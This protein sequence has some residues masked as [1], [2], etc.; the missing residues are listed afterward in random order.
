[1]SKYKVSSSRP[2][3]YAIPRKNARR[4]ADVK[5]LGVR[6][7]ALRGRDAGQSE[8]LGL[9]RESG[10]C[11]LTLSGLNNA[12][13]LSFFV[14]YAQRDRYRRRIWSRSFHRQ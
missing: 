3:T 9:A 13:V 11:T 6:A 14:M 1:M 2:L 5:K 7:E 12:C 8:N 4:R 10:N